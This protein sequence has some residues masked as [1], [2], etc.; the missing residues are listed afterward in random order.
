MAV[1]DSSLP[2]VHVHSGLRFV[3][4]VDDACALGLPDAVELGPIA[5]VPRTEATQQARLLCAINDV[6][7]CCSDLVPVPEGT[8]RRSL[9]QLHEKSLRPDGPSLPELSPRETEML[10]LLAEGLDT[11]EIAEKLIYSERTVKNVLHNLL[12]RLDLRNRTHAVAYA[13]RRG[14]L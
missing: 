1:V 9:Q 8:L 2:V 10:R 12:N 11:A 6:H 7:D 5:L 4:I 13:L 3:L 14:L